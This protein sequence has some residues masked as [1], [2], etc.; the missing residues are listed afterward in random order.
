MKIT[1]V[2]HSTVLFEMGGRRILTDPFFNSWGNIAFKR[3]NSPALSREECSHVD[4]VLV[5]HDHWDHTDPAY[6]RLLGNI[7]VVVPRLTNWL[8][9]LMGA[10]NTIPIDPW[11]SLN[12]GGI[13]IHVVP[14]VH[15]TFS[16]GYV[17]QFGDKTVYFA[18]DTFHRPFMK[19]IARKFRLDAVLIPV[20]TFRLP[21]TMGEKQ[22]ARAVQDLNPGVVIPM[23]MGVEQRMPWLRSGQTAE[24]FMQLLETRG[25]KTRV[26][27]LHEGESYEIR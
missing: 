7:P 18:G 21:M 10:K 26:A 5:S 15:I 6:F 8:F 20:T 12:L 22:A 17:I 1:M 27:L 25:C 16:Q 23:H 2:G 11:E 24:G 3:L 13:T 19:D 4:G 9:R 14:A